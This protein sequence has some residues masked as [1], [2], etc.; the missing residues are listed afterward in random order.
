MIVCEVCGNEREVGCRCPYCGTRGDES[1]LAERRPFQHRT[2][3]LEA[4]RPTVD[5]ALHRLTKVIDD[6][7]RQKIAVLT[8]IH[9]Y[10]SSGKGGVIREECRKTLDHLKNRG[11][12]KDYVAG[13]DFHK[14]HQQVKSLLQRFPRLCSDF[15]LNRNNKGITLVVLS[16]G[17]MYCI[18][19][20]FTFYTTLLS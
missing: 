15:N 5:L 16:Y 7:I 2:V 1:E 8:V 12:I 14:N 19:P 13:E 11:T 3:N 9:G 18:L 6:A 4:G 20:V 17:L 10:G